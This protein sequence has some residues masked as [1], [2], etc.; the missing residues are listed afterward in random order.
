[1]KYIVVAGGLTRDAEI[2]TLQTGDKVTGFAV[3]VDEGFGDKKRTLYFDCNFWGARGEKL[4]Q[5]LTKGSKVAVSGE[6]STR[7][8]DG[9]T[10]LTVRVADLTLL[11]GKPTEARQEAPMAQRNAMDIDDAVPFAPEVR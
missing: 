10:Y 7:D 9:K 11:G 6:L 4:A 3:A 2:R 5:Y 1:M 8:H